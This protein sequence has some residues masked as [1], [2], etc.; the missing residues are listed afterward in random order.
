MQDEIQVPIQNFMCKLL[1]PIV[2]CPIIKNLWGKK[3]ISLYLDIQ[4]C[5]KV[6]TIEGKSFIESEIFLPGCN[7]LLLI[8]AE[9]HHNLLKSLHSKTVRKKNK[10]QFLHMKIRFS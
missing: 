5:K 7:N 2:R 9:Q 4:S 3:S 10:R 6:S 1:L 8:L